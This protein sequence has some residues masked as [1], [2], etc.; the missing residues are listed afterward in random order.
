MA[1]VRR[2][3]QGVRRSAAAQS[4][5]RKAQAARRRTHSLLDRAIGLLPFSEE[6]LHKIFL[7]AII[8]AMLGLAWTVASF[9]GLPELA[10]L[11]LAQAASKSGFEVRDVEVTGVDRLSEQVVYGRV[12][13]DRDRPMPLVDL[14]EVRQRL[15][16]L[17]W[18]A[19]ARVSRV[20]PDTLK[21][22]IVERVP[23]AVLRKPDRLVLIDAEGHELEPISPAK[24]KG[25]LLIGGPGAQKQV[26]ALGRLLDAAPAL[27][28]Q[29][30]EAEWV[31][32]RRWNLT[33]R[34]GQVLALP[35]G[36]E[37]PA[38]LVKFAQLDGMHRLI[39]GKAIAID[40]RVP[41]RAYLR[42][43]DGP[44]PGPGARIERAR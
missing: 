32:N 25:K 9:A 36:E 5:S 23:H 24:A 8:A 18:V 2:K 1:T 33:F 6:Q 40:M 17:P 14:E 12:L 28:P 4:R 29:I 16:D 35:E 31:G 39:G 3:P 37:G 7:T 42:C 11:H 27:K 19:D 30:A 26:A 13:A 20:L 15:L 10:R 21:V 34:T 22:D 44:C 41:D 43:E 38:A